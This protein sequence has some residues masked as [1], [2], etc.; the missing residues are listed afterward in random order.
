MKNLK[1][2]ALYSLIAAF[3]ATF[4]AS[5]STSNDV[6]NNSLIQKRK[7]RSGFYVNKKAD[8]KDPVI[9]V[10][11]ADVALEKTVVEPQVASIPQSKTKLKVIEKVTE[12]LAEKKA[13]SQAKEPKNST[14]QQPDVRRTSADFTTG[15]T[16]ASLVQR[17][18]MDENLKKAIIFAAVATGISLVASITYAIT[19]S[20]VIY[21]LLLALSI[22]CV[23]FCI[24]NLVEFFKTL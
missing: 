20:V 13:E 24:I 6:V 18:A 22:V 16:M 15:V 7:Y 2:I 1:R 21:Y 3:G 17:R 23:V 19:G 10:Q 11:K 14:R 5:C 9:S 4:F 12:R 8:K